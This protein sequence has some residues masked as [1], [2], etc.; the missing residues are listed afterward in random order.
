MYRRLEIIHPE[1]KYY[2]QG[3]WHREPATKTGI[4]GAVDISWATKL[5]GPKRSIPQNTRFFFTER[6]WKEIGRH[7]VA[8]CK[9]VV[10]MCA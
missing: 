6:G 4:L 8:A 5:R 1:L 9:K 10:R 7:V 2:Y 3:A